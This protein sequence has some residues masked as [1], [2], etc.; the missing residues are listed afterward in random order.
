MKKGDAIFFG[1][2]IALV[3]IL[4]FAGC[5]KPRPP[6]I[7]GANATGGSELKSFQ[8]WDDIS[9]FV[10]SSGG[11]GYGHYLVNKGG[12][13]LE[14]AVM[15]TA[16]PQASGALKSQEA[17]AT[18]YSKTNVQVEGVDEADI[19]KNDGKYIYAVLGNS[20]YYY[21]GSQKGKVAIIDAY[22][23]SGMQTV[24]ETEIDGTVQGLFIFNDKLVVFGS[25]YRNDILPPALPTD[26]S[27]CVM[28]PYYSQNF[29]FMKIYEVSDH[30]NPKLVKEIESKGSYADSRMIGGKVYAVFS[31]YVD[32]SYPVPLYAV[33]GIAKP[34]AATEVE[35]FD[36]PDSNYQYNVFVGLDL[37]NLN[38]SENRKI[39][40][41][42]AGQNLFVSQDNMYVTYSRYGY[43]EPQWKA[44]Q[45]TYWGMMPDATRG[46]ILQIDAMNLSDWRKDGLKV[47][48]AQAFSESYIYNDSR[49]DF[50]S[51]SQRAAL[52]TTLN[53]KARIASSAQASGSERTVINKISLEGFSYLAKGEVPGQALNQFSMDESNGYFRIATTSEQSAGAFGRMPMIGNVVQPT[54]SNAVYVLDSNLDV[55]GSLEGLAPGEKIYSARF[56]GERLYL[57]TFKTVDPLFVIDLSNPAKP[58]LLGKLK[59]PGYSDY[60]HPYDATH[61]IGIGKDVDES[62]DADKV[63]TAGAV[64]YTAIKGVKLSLFDVSDVAH[65]QEVA[66]YIIGDRGTDSYALSEHKAFLFDKG[67]N[68]LVIPITLA[69]IDTAKYPGGVVPTSASGDFVFQGAYVFNVTLQEGFRLRGSITHA[70]Q[71]DLMKS[72]EY[73]LSDSSV[74]RSLYMGSSLYTVSDRYVKANDLSTLAPI[75]SVDFGSASQPPFRYYYE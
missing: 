3:F 41:M 46:K 30:A 25:A 54:T 22:P 51:A 72:G 24:S 53:E 69:V 62:I 21:G 63:H 13:V 35:Y 19:V 48:E 68:L 49:K 66:K 67:K 36:S 43:Y 32:R 8:S 1:I 65:P 5:T 52:E 56:M 42:G 28:P 39:I 27:R 14:D 60:L 64:Y 50:I 9:S 26:C 34:V 17:A 11:S 71:G 45:E 15:P 2:A 23:A 16:A 18:D 37:N 74:K 61:L 38:G 40:M 33:D 31:D 70:S 59:I 44:Y 75:S 7:P 47:A 57:V 6:G 58:A 55:A 10:Q 73:F 20:N 29:A 4:L 12:M